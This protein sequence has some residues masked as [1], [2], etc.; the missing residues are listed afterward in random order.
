MLDEYPALHFDVFARTDPGQNDDQ[1]V[2]AHQSANRNDPV[3]GHFDDAARFEILD[4][5]TSPI[6]LAR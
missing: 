4:T 2:S 3:A 1:P 6:K 5:K